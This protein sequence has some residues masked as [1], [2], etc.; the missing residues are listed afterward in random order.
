MIS[1]GYNI[2]L[3]EKK[4]P[5]EDFRKM[6]IIEFIRAIKIKRLPQK[7]AIYGLDT[8]LLSVEK[9]R[10]LLSS[11]R[12]ILRENNRDFRRNKYTFLFIPRNELDTNAY[13]YA[14]KGNKKANISSLFAMRLNIKDINLYYAGF[15]F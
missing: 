8:L 12:E 15:D 13:V 9:P 1:L 5:P 2:S 11:I 4:K 6:S 7:V 10:D 3:D 14:K